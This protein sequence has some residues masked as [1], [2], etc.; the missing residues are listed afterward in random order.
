MLQSSAYYARAIRGWLA[1]RTRD[2]T[3]NLFW[4]Y[5]WSPHRKNGQL[6]SGLQ[7]PRARG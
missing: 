2:M 3:A 4:N 5:K 6:G 1:S 7:L